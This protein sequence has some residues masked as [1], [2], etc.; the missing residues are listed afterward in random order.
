[1]KEY[2]LLPTFVKIYMSRLDLDGYVYYVIIIEESTQS[3]VVVSLRAAKHRMI[4]AREGAT[5]VRSNMDSAWSKEKLIIPWK[6]IMLPNLFLIKD[7]NLDSLLYMM[8]IWEIVSLR[9][10]KNIYSPIS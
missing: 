4:P 9:I 6:I 2:N 8:A 1:M 5:K 3:F 10:F 7:A